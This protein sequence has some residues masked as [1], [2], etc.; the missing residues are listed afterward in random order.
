MADETEPLLCSQEVRNFASQR[1]H[2]ALISPHIERLSPSAASAIS[3]RQIM[4]CEALIRIRPMKTRHVSGSAGQFLEL[5]DRILV[6]ILGVYRFAGA[7]IEDMSCH[8]RPLVMHA[9]EVHLDASEGRIVEGMMAKGVNVEVG[10]ELAIDAH[11]Q[12]EVELRGNALSVV[13]GRV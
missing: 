13:V 10:A 5:C 8:C 12:I 4:D 1:R 3:D 9:D 7:K 6:G 2:G 11:E